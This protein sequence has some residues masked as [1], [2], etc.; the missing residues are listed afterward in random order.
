MERLS[1]SEGPGKKGEDAQILLPRN[2]FQQEK[3]LFIA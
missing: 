3:M 1:L 2:M